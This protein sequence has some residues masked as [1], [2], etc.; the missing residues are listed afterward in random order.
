[1]YLEQNQPCL[2]QTLEESSITKG[3]I[4]APIGHI[5]CSDMA[6]SASQK[7]QKLHSCMVVNF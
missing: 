5:F 6:L 1:M 3:H 7:K 4:F 2:F